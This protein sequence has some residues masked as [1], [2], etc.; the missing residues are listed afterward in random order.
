[1]N[2]TTAKELEKILARF[3]AQHSGGARQR[4]NDWLA[5]RKTLIGG[6]EV[7]AL[8]GRNAYMSKEALVA[9]KAGLR[10]FTGNTACRWGTLFEP[11]IEA[12]VE[13]DCG[14]RLMGTDIS[15][16]APRSS[17]L[18]GL[19]ANSPDGYGVVA[20]Y[21]D[22]GD[23]VWRLRATDAE[24]AE[25]ADGLPICHII[26]LFEFKCPFRRLPS[27]PSA[28]KSVPGHYLP[29]VWSGLAVSPVAH[30][31]IFVDAVFR[32]CSLDSLGVGAEYDHEYHRECGSAHWDGGPVAWGLIAVFAP[33]L[34]AARRSTAPVV[35]AAGDG[36]GGDGGGGGGGGDG[37]FDPSS[38]LQSNSKGAH[39]HTAWG[40]YRRYF[41]VPFGQLRDGLD[42]VDFG[43]CDADVFEDA[44]KAIDAKGFRTELRGPCMSDGRGL[45]LFTPDEICTVIDSCAAAAGPSEFLLGVLPWKA[46]EVNYTFVQRRP[47]FLEEIEP[48]VRECLAATGQ[49]LSAS[50]AARAYDEYLSDARAKKAS[51]RAGA[52]GPV[53]AAQPT[54]AVQA[55]FDSLDAD[56]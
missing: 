43:D 53:V 29:Q 3:V 8:M 39:A 21:L 37:D 50:D 56:P 49:I 4:S 30:L 19:H 2:P 12:V 9:K 10:P 1:M 20:L 14:T 33:R 51:S 40:L 46:F 41:N 48:H 45:P 54:P 47:G 11:V 26:A 15:V 38:V 16:A 7:A 52:I 36:G 13:I 22:D 24:T 31:G 5:G 27:A 55:F 42:L 44:L 6:S 35:D 17:G 34:S 18:Q 28:K 23:G 32:K 25:A